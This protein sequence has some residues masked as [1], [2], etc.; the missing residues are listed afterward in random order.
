MITLTI[1]SSKPM[2]V[3]TVGLE[4]LSLSESKKIADILDDPTA[5]LGK[6]DA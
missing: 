2:C 4:A 6:K 1:H 5:S 3:D